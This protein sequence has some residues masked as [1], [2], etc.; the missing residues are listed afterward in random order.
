M[1]GLL[2]LH[3]GNNVYISETVFSLQ[4]RYGGKSNEKVYQE[5]CRYVFDR[6]AVRGFNADRLF[7]G[8]R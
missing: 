2:C 5:S 7:L 4:K 8:E 6:G 3:N 1:G